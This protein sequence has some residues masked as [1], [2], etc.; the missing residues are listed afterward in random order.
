MKKSFP[1]LKLFIYLRADDEE[2]M[3]KEKK[4]TTKKKSRGVCY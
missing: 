3:I 2:K 4:K 1:L